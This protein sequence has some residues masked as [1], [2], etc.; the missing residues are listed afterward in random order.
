MHLCILIADQFWYVFVRKVAWTTIMDDILNKLFCEVVDYLVG[1]RDQWQVRW[2][3]KNLLLQAD[4]D[5]FLDAL[6]VSAN[7][8]LHLKCL[9]ADWTLQILLNSYR[10]DADWARCAE[11]KGLCFSA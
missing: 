5:V 7:S 8:G 2:W 9:T 11:D 4:G 6:F 10:A 3:N 1:C